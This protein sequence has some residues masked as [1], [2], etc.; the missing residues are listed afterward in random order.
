M[1]MARPP[2]TLIA[3]FLV[4][5]SLVPA[6]AEQAA[7]VLGKKVFLEIAKPSCGR[8]HTLADAGATG[9][10]GQ[11]LD[12]LKPTADQ[13]RIAVTKGIGP[14][15]PNTLLTKEQIDAVATYVAAVAGR[16]SR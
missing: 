9:T 11:N 15:P 12:N 10:L 6:A 8:C 1:T 2:R 13:I 4:S 3:A 14:M 16:T 7:L 5:T